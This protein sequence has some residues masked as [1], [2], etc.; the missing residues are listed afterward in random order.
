MVLYTRSS[1][2]RGARSSTSS[3]RRSCDWVVCTTTPTRRARQFLGQVVPGTRPPVTAPRRT[4]GRASTSGMVLLPQD[5]HEVALVAQRGRLLLG[6]LDERAG[7]VHDGGV[8]RGEPLVD[9]A[10]HSVGAEDDGTVP[11]FLG[12]RDDLDSALLQVRDDPWVVDQRA[13]GSAPDPAPAPQLP[14]PTQGRAR[15]PSRSRRSRRSSLASR[16]NVSPARDAS[17]SRNAWFE[18]F[19]HQ[20]SPLRSGHVVAGQLERRAEGDTRPW[21]G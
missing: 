9:L 12:L 15:P 18:P 13:R 16:L 3:A 20:L 7:G 6:R 14:A 11:G 4:S 1:R 2:T 17:R 10:R 21:A 8:G 5:D 19:G